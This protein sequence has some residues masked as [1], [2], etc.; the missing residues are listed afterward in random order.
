MDFSSRNALDHDTEPFHALQH[1]GDDAITPQPGPLTSPLHRIPA[2]IAY[3]RQQL[4]T[5]DKPVHFDQQA[6]DR[7]WPYV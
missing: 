2:D 3:H 7:Y 1:A 5:L 6:W 4:F